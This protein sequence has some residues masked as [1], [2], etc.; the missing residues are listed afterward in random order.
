M[1]E[2]LVISDYLPRP[3]NLSRVVLCLSAVLLFAGCPT[4]E[5]CAAG[6]VSK[7]GACVPE[8]VCGVGTTAMNNTCVANVSCAAGTTAVGGLCV[9]DTT[10]G[11]GT[12]VVDGGCVPD[13]KCGAGTT[14][15]NGQCVPNCGPGTSAADGGCVPDVLC[16]PGTTAV[17]GRCVPDVTCG[18][19]TRPVGRSCVPD[20]TVVCTQGTRFEADG[21]TCVVDPTACAAGT[22]LV[23]TQCVTDGSLLMGMANVLEGAEVTDGGLSVAGTV[24]LPALNA[25]TTFYGCITPV[26]SEVDRDFWL[27]TA[28]GP[29][30]L[31]ITTDGING[32]AA[33]FVVLANDPAL[34][35]VLANWQR[36]GINLTG[37]TSRRDVYLPL[38][39]TYAI[40]V[41]DS[42]DLLTGSAAG[43]SDTCYFATVKQ[44]ALPVPTVLALPQTSSS[45]DGHVKLFTWT[46]DGAGD[47]LSVST[48]TTAPALE[49]AFIALEGTTLHRVAGP[50]G[51]G[52]PPSDLVGGLNAGDVVTIVFDAQ[53]NYGLGPQGFTLDGAEINA[54]ALP[55]SGLVLTVTERNGTSTNGLLDLNYQYFDV[56]SAGLVHF[57]VV[58]SVPV[59]MNIVREDVV[60]A[61]GSFDFFALINTFGGTGQAAFQNEFVRFLTPGRYYFVTQNP[62]ATMAGGTYTLTSTLTNVGTTPLTLGT[63][64]AGTLGVGNSSFHTLDLTDPIWLE[65]G[66]LGTINWGTGSNVSLEQYDLA[67]GGWLRSGAAPGTL[68]AGH[69]YPV[70]S[71]TQP[72]V[73]PFAPMGRILARETR[74]FLVRIKPTGTPGTGPTYSLLVQNRP[75]VV[76]LNTL[77]PGTPVSPT[78]TA[79]ANG[80]PAR[81]IAFGT[82][83]HTLRALAHPTVATT[84]I[85]ELRVNASEGVVAT[86]DA[87]LLGGD[88][89]LSA[90]FSAAPADWIAWTV[91]NLTPAIGTDVNLTVTA[92]APRPYVITTGTIPFVDACVGGGVTLGTNQDDQIFAGQTLPPAFSAF[93]LFGDNVPGTFRIGA[94]GWLSWDTGTVSFGA[95]QNRAIPTV[96]AP[97]GMIAP[98]WQDQDTNTICRKDDGMANTVTIQ[99]TGRIYQTPGQLVQYQVRLAATGVIDFIYGPNHTTTGG[100][101]DSDGN[102]ATVG[103]ENLGGTFGHQ[104][105]FNQA[106]ILPNTSRTLTPQ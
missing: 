65:F 53:S 22:T 91:E 77:T 55:T 102:G 44:V 21:G 33:G 26:G 13:V 59:D 66:V 3:M 81:F 30:V 1:V 68:P 51:M 8:V 4:A 20:G 74:D 84:N 2:G 36:L 14:A 82:P 60:L 57:N 5:K 50:D 52:T 105:L 29:T 43:A 46:A 54:A 70:F 12:T 39:G 90:A 11:T 67:L 27:I 87:T 72:S 48:S 35:P 7:D 40:M 23:G 15:M 71:G 56:A 16:G 6:S 34:Q 42:R 28:T 32:L 69:L 103:A 78:I 89:T 95:Y 41:A 18:P 96:G 79:L 10:C 99:W 106:G 97:E 75:N 104:I 19:G 17:N 85:R 63:A 45:D 80:S 61:N 31:E 9:P 88:E 37:D 83:G 76:N 92:T 64:A 94:N 62:A 38:A 47:I 86:F 24:A 100:F 98:F 93:Q 58:A 25:S 73:T 101:V 49:T